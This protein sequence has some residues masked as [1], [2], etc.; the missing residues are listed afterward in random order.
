MKNIP[1][2]CTRCGAPIS[3]EE[4]AS[5][6]KCEF[7]GYKNNL[8][9]DFIS[10]FKN[11]LKLRDPKKII[12]NPFPLILFLPV[13]FLFLILNS[14]IKKQ[15]KIK[16][17]YW[18]TDW[19]KL[20]QV[21]V[22]NKKSPIFGK[23]IPL[24][25]DKSYKELKT[26][27]FK[28][29]LNEACEYTK[30]LAKDYQSYSLQEEKILYDFNIFVGYTPQFG[31]LIPF[32]LYADTRSINA[33][34]IKSE[35]FNQ[36]TYNYDKQRT[37]NRLKIISKFL[38]ENTNTYLDYFDYY[39]KQ[40]DSVYLNRV[41]E[42]SKLSSEAYLKLNS[43]YFE[44]MRQAGDENWKF[45]NRWSILSSMGIGDLRGFYEEKYKNIKKEKD[46]SWNESD[47][48]EWLL[49]KG[50]LKESDFTIIKNDLKTD[51]YFKHS[52]ISL[53]SKARNICNMPNN[54]FL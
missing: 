14:P 53:R 24:N 6:V 36:K 41:S 38:K 40:Y 19:S 7:C 1:E 48:N 23:K 16:A 35:Y 33:R 12:R 37:I 4:G 27:R 45:A 3:W 28:K 32:E 34:G 52:A 30:S 50:I 47:F 39:E 10:L 44:V 26:T 25:W 51:K 9:D 49:K 22:K 46:S 17:E 31:E 5:I 20:K 29:D 18:P 2:K 15:E 43:S 8:R 11:Y 21:K 42:I 13:I 54:N